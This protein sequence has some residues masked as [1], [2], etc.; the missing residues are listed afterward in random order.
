MNKKSK[1]KN[2]KIP[3]STFQKQ[4]LTVLCNLIFVFVFFLSFF[5]QY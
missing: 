3:N 2:Y 5:P 1:I 4:P